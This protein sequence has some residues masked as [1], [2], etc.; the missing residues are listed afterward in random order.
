MPQKNFSEEEIQ[1][2][3]ALIELSEPIETPNN[4]FYSF[5]PKTLQEAQAYFRRFTL[6]LPDAYQR[7]AEDDYLLHADGSWQLTAKGR[8]AA[9]QVRI[10]RPPI[11]YWYKDFYQSSEHSQAFSHYC[12]EVF[13]LDLSQLGFSDMQQIHRVL[14]LLQLV[15]GSSLLDIGCGRGK[16][17]EYISDTTHCRVLGIDYIP[18]AI[19]QACR[20]TK[21]KTERLQFLTADMN[22]LD[23]DGETFDAI[24]S[25][26]SIFFGQ[27]LIKTVERLKKLLKP[28]GQ[29]A[30]FCADDLKDALQRN[31]LD[32]NL[33]DLSPE[34]YEHLQHKHRIVSKMQAEFEAESNLFIW[35]NL[36]TESLDE[37]AAFD[38]SNPYMRRFLYHVK[39]RLAA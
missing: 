16:I 22:R 9:R 38:P 32:Y 27:D 15:Q 17:A 7:L 14:G 4:N 33:Y 34:N 35:E 1:A 30:I 19:L 18:E 26:D 28:G 10:E 3:I 20:R 6:D 8:E 24:L 25:I 31:H 11:W 37:S 13:G 2:L 36:M 5:F 12:K 29:M 23:L 21:S 39:K